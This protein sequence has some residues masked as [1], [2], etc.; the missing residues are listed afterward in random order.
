M[1]LL[2]LGIAFILL[3]YFAVNPVA[4]WSWWL[5]LSPFAGAFVWWQFA[6]ATGYTQR[7]AMEEE[8]KER[9]ERIERHRRELG[10]KPHRRR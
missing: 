3:K 4:E 6:D 7:R 5:V 8:E 10:F 2:G 1:Y 9:H